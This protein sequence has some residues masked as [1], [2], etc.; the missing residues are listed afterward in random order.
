MKR[1]FNEAGIA[2]ND[3]LLP[4]EPSQPPSASSTDDE[5][6][7]ASSCS[8]LSSLDEN[9]GSLSTCPLT[10]ITG[11]LLKSNTSEKK[12]KSDCSSVPEITNLS[13]S[14][15]TG[16]SYQSIPFS[17][18]LNPLK[19]FSSNNLKKIM[20]DED[21]KIHSLATVYSLLEEKALN[22]EKTDLRFL[23]DSTGQA[24][25]ARETHNDFPAPAHY[26]MTGSPQS[27][28]YCR[29][30]GNLFFSSDYK[31]LN[32]V[33]NKSGDFRPSFDSLKWFLAILILNE[34][35]LP[36]AFPELLLVDEFSSSGRLECTLKLNVSELRQWILDTF[37]DKNILE[38]LKIQIQETKSVSYIKEQD[39]DFHFVTSSYSLFKFDCSGKTDCAKMPGINLF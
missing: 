16:T 29:T 2:F 31:F 26:Q 13:L 37:T 3:I 9:S 8:D 15:S 23:V 38:E 34:D 28:A 17:S 30:S 32:R 7:G 22:S 39:S 18:E 4:I 21:Y 14:Y 25:F 27:Q 35:S 10:T 5:G 36:F 6:S 20:R 11:S 24:W 19:R 1:K 33:N 12:R